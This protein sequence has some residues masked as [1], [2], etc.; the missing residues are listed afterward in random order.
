MMGRAKKVAEQ[1]GV[2]RVAEIG[3]F[4]QHGIYVHQATRPGLFHH[5][6]TGINTGSQGKGFSEEAS[7]ISAVME[8][9]EAYCA[10]PRDVELVRASYNQLIQAHA[11][12]APRCM[13]EIG[14]GYEPIGDDEILM[15]TRAKLLTEGDEVFV[16]A[17]LVYMFLMPQMFETRGA[18]RVTGG[19]LGAHFTYEL[20]VEKAVQE[21]IEHHYQGRLNDLENVTVEWLEPNRE[22]ENLKK[23][24]NSDF[25][26]SFEANF[27]VVTLNEWQ[28]NIPFVLCFLGNSQ[29]N[30]VGYGLRQDPRQA[31]QAAFL[32]A[33]Q[34][35][36]TNISGVRE[37]LFN[38]KKSQVDTK[39]DKFQQN[40]DQVWPDQPNL[41][42]RTYL[43]RCGNHRLSGLSLLQEQMRTNGYCDIFV[44]NLSRPHVDC[45]VARALIP[46]LWSIQGGYRRPDASTQVGA[47]GLLKWKYLA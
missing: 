12:V 34:C 25:W 3:R 29:K 2:T 39:P 1:I 35:W 21:R 16:P 31:M 18:Y 14:R 24:I 42:L 15:W 7:Y 37:D 9:A 46:A 4:L 28:S 33:Y 6:K 17:E 13:Q 30:Y 36:V 5:Y 10:E 20:A 45:F 47:S 38:H 19:G 44:V 32:E 26:D 11:A 27:F 43:K 41:S 40:F 22:T 8:S 23:H